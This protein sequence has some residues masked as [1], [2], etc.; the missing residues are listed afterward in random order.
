LIRDRLVVGI[1][2]CHLLEHLQ[3]D[4][5]LTLELSVQ[6]HILREAVTQQTVIW[7]DCNSTVATPRK[8]GNQQTVDQQRHVP[9]VENILMTIVQPEMLHA[10]DATEEG[11]K[12][13]V[14]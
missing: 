5:K 14:V 4:A 7:T 6:K 12:L 9:T 2:D 10:I 13:G 3:L 8:H 1:C 11:I